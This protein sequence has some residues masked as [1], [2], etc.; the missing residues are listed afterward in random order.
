MRRFYFSSRRGLLFP[1]QEAEYVLRRSRSTQGEKRKPSVR[2]IP[3]HQRVQGRIAA[4]GPL[5]R[6]RKM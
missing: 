1:I 2:V 3:S 4:K 5:P 6:T